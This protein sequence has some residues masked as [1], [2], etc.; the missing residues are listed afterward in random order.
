[1]YDS[2]NTQVS[3]YLSWKPMACR[4]LSHKGFTLDVDRNMW[5]CGDCR[6]PSQHNSEYV[7]E[8]MWCARTVVLWKWW[9]GAA[10]EA[11]CAA[12]PGGPQNVAGINQTTM[13]ESLAAEKAVKEYR[14]K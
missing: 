9:D 2:I 1:M 14:A 7:T 12:C 13:D 10:D 6:K 4:T 11:V 8:C 5:V 3:G